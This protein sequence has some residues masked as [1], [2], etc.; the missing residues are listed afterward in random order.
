MDPIA[1]MLTQIRNSINVGQKTCLV[2][3]SK[4]K[5]EILKKIKEAN[6]IHDYRIEEKNSK[7]NIRVSL[8]YDKNNKSVINS[9][10]RISK[11]GRRVYQTYEKLPYVLGGM[12]I[13]ILSTSKGLMNDKTARAQKVGGEVVCEIW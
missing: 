12:G 2:R 8:A 11:P 3:Y 6:Y 13:L 7:K 4:I 9:I 10:K 5:E 1:D